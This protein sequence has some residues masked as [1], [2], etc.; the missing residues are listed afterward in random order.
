MTVTRCAFCHKPMD[1]S[2]SFEIREYNPDGSY[3]VNKWMHAKCACLWR[4][5]QKIATIRDSKTIPVAALQAVIEEL[6]NIEQEAMHDYFESQ[7]R[8]AEYWVA[9]GRGRLADE[10]LNRFTKLL[11]DTPDSA[12]EAQS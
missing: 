11:P 5:Q 7:Y 4:E 12:K 6:R 9:V 3:F 1:L 10:I 2:N 8:S